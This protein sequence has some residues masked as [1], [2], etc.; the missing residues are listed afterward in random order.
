MDAVL[1]WEPEILLHKI[2]TTDPISWGKLHRFEN[3]ECQDGRKVKVVEVGVAQ[4]RSKTAA[5]GCSRPPERA[6][7]VCLGKWETIPLSLG[8]RIIPSSIHNVG[9]GA[10]EKSKM[11]RFSKV[12]DVSSSRSRSCTKHQGDPG[13]V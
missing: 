13:G 2:R 4:S 8:A 7:T 9:K 1:P 3:S 10:F 11:I 6:H 12:A 5:V